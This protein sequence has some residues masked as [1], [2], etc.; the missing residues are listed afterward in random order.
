MLKVATEEIVFGKCKQ[1]QLVKKILIWAKL[2]AKTC[3][4]PIATNC[5]QFSDLPP[6]LEENSIARSLQGLEVD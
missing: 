4:I 2:D 1:L 6:A 5:P 3:S